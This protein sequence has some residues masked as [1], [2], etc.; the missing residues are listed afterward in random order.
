M[1]KYKYNDKIYCDEDLS[2]EIDNYGGD[3]QQLLWDIEDE[4][5]QIQSELTITLRF[6]GGEYYASDD[7]K[8]DEETLDEIVECGYE[9]VEE[10]L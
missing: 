4:N 10:L 1:K 7:E 2:C 5:P 3:L 8:S 6:I 9:E